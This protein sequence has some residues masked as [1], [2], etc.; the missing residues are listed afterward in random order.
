MS[1]KLPIVL[2]TTLSLLEQFQGALNAPP[3]TPASNEPKR[4]DALPL[5]TAS[6]DALKSQ[7]TKLS[8]LTINTPFTPSAVC[9]VL[10]ALNESVLP[11]LVTASLLVTPKE[12]TKAFHAEIQILTNLTLK[13]LA[14]LIGEVKTVADKNDKERSEDPKKKEEGLSQP[15]KDVVTIATGRVWDSCDALIDLATKGVVGF[16][17]RRVEQW[18][19]LV[20]DAVE[21]IEEWDPEEDDDAFFEEMLG[22]DGKKGPGD[23]NGKDSDEEEED[24]DDDDEDTALSH[25]NKKSALRVLKPV[26]QI[27]PAIVTNRL[28]NAGDKPLS[29]NAGVSKLE[30]LMTNLQSIPEDIDEVAGAL[31]EA[32]WDRYTEFLVKVKGEAAKAVELVV[33]QWDAGVDGQQAE[34]KFT[35]WSKTWLKVV[36]EVSKSIGGDAT[37]SKQC[38]S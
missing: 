20:R 7:V 12:F 30:F 5:L 15:E 25:A 8:L 24:D 32:K 4:N 28:K 19:D 35:T 33:T 6:S 21:E 38:Q 17:I 18:R 36:D 37:S 10:S 11:S 3:Q 29:S 2:T 23:G 16:V 22:D 14:S 34:D 13:E 9:T 26:G 31:Y 27:F 1:K